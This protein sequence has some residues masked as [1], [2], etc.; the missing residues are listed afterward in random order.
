MGGQE[1]GEVG[2]QPR[3][4]TGKA[5][6][7]TCSVPAARPRGRRDGSPAG[8][9][10]KRGSVRSFA[11]RGHAAP[12][13]VAR[14]LPVAAAGRR[15]WKGPWRPH[16]WGPRGQSPLASL[17]EPKPG[18]GEPEPEARKPA[19]NSDAGP[20][21]GGAHTP[22]A[23]LRLGRQGCGLTREKA[24]RP[25]PVLLLS[26]PSTGFTPPHPPPQKRTTTK[27]PLRLH[28]LWNRG[29]CHKSAVCGGC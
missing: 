13:A 20:P 29:L 18:L 27:T 2:C 5:R 22:V 16:A 14:A 8:G 6:D 15:R 4:L 7:P 19:A 21:R 28:F 1:R 3:V 26:G 10:G 11:S 23:V 12:G 17:L 24:S 25:S 9:R